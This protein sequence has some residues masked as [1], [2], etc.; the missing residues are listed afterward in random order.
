[1]DIEYVAHIA[2]KILTAVL[3]VALHSAKTIDLSLLSGLVNQMIF[4]SPFLGLACLAS[5]DFQFL[6]GFLITQYLVKKLNEN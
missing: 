6:F 5:D 2:L 3:I 4:I 1:M